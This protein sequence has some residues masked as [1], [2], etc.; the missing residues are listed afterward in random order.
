M[1]NTETAAFLIL[2]TEAEILHGAGFL[3]QWGGSI[4]QIGMT[5]FI[6]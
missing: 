6:S 5:G 4:T 1:K 3:S 2:F